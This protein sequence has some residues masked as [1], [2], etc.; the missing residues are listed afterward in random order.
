MKE[1]LSLFI[2]SFLLISNVNAASL[3]D[4]LTQLNN[5]FKE[6]AITKEEFS[7]AKSLLLKTETEPKTKIKKRVKKPKK[8]EIK[9]TAE[10]NFDQNL[11]K[12]YVSLDEIDEL[13]TF[14][15]ISEAPEGMFKPSRKTF[16]ARAAKSSEGMYLTF[17]QHKHLMEKY[18][19]NLMKAMGY[20]EFFYMEQLRKKEKNMRLFKEKWPN[21]PS[22]IKTDIKS[23]Y[24]LN[25]ARK[26]MRES[27]GLT[28][29]DDIQ[30]ALQRYMLMH[31]F[32][33]QAKKTRV[34]LT[35][36][37][38]KLRKQSN[39]FKTS[40][41]SLKKIVQLRKEKRIDEK[42]FNK[43]TTKNINS[44]KQALKRL[45]FLNSDNSKFYKIINEL[46]IETTK[47]TTD[48]ELTL[49]AINVI[50]GILNDI[51]KDIIPREYIQNLKHVKIETIPED[52]KKILAAISLGM[53]IQKR[54]KKKLL[55]AS[56][57]N[58]S[59]NGFQIESYINAIEESGFDLKSIT[60]TF[61]DYDNMKKWVSKDW[62]QSWK[63]ELPLEVKDTDGNLVEFTN[64]NI[65]DIKAQLAMNT[66]NEMISL[67]NNELKDSIND[68][69]KDIAK[70]IKSSGGFDIDTYLNQDFTITL[71][72]Y[73]QLVGNAI[74]IEINNF[75]D[76]TKVANE[77][78][79]SQIT[80]EDYANKWETSQYMDSTSNWKDIT[81]GVDLIDQV[82][83][84]DAATIAK[85][86]GADLQTVA[87][88]IAQAAAIGVSTDLEAAAQ[89]LG[90]DSFA[91]AVA[92]YNAEHGTSYTV[93]TAKEALGQ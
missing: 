23:L 36:E 2:L 58:L 34:K 64:E 16:S 63:G 70:E 65:Q 45:S 52:N 74:G 75:K 3:A 87:D 60:M 37:E 90:Y 71:N 19:E 69:I 13:G 7:K 25:Q 83:S 42:E 24:S 5:L 79:G 81:I 56:L 55:Q 44:A 89:G 4:D 12:S 93:E 68:S 82:G 48:L 59:N 78:Y 66:F 67:D 20:F 15:K 29:N 88:S 40:L 22:Y 1:I 49:N 91:D 73:S 21:I 46:F 77:F 92:A 10:K 50:N 35:S 18:P 14:R 51:E 61:D 33:I 17:V 8:K 76:L 57:L 38:K 80:A 39:I 43:S 85:D 54:D 53:K 32:L 47:N 62:A 84:F 11:T 9:K 31:N 41:N 28:L 27:M 30:V 86:L 26:T 6:G 72:N